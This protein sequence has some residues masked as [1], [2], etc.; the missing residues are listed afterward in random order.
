MYIYIYKVLITASL[1]TVRSFRNNNLD[2][3]CCLFLDGKEKRAKYPHGRHPDF[4]SFNKE[5]DKKKPFQGRRRICSCHLNKSF[6]FLLTCLSVYAG[7]FERNPK[8]EEIQPSRVTTSA[9][10]AAAAPPHTNAAASAVT[11]E[12]QPA[13]LANRQ[14]D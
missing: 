11:T 5:C 7:R 2:V 9:A 1:H 4:R 14:T 3:G 13:L 12:G 8:S 10:A 6:F